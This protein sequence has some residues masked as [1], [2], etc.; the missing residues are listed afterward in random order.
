ME[1]VS[2][3]VIPECNYVSKACLLQVVSGWGSQLNFDPTNNIS[4][5]DLLV[6]CAIIWNNISASHQDL[7]KDFASEFFSQCTD[8]LSGFCPQGRTTR[9]W[10]III[11]YYEYM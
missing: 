11:A 5:D 3:L 6:G 8:M 4:A 10:Q 2:A 9:L 1:S 7:Q